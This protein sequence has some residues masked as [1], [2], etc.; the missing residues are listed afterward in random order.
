M[1][2]PNATVVQLQNEVISYVDDL[3]HFGKDSLGK[4]SDTLRCPG[5][6]F[7]PFLFGS[8]S[9]KSLLVSYKLMRYYETVGRPL[10]ADN[11]QWN[12]RIL[13]FG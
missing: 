12:T 5:G 7:E 9:H 11:M 6:G 1:A 2:I 10:M 3:I 13:N 8:K 4:S